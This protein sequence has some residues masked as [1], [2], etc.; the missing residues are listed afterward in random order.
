MC[1]LLFP[2]MMIQNLQAVYLD[3][4]NIS[5]TDCGGNGNNNKCNIPS[6]LAVEQWEIRLSKTASPHNLYEEKCSQPQNSLLL[7]YYINVAKMY[8][9]FLFRSREN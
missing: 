4:I 1:V 3:K 5:Q 6:V 9:T 2:K 7:L 8:V